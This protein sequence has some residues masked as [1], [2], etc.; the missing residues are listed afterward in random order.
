M[1]FH[2]YVIYSPESG[3]MFYGY[4]DDLEKVVEMHN[5]NQIPLT[6]GRGPWVLVFSEPWGTRMQAIRQSRFYRTVK[7]QRFLKNILHF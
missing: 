7:G 6:R 3:D 5:A 2:S 4:F 1:Q